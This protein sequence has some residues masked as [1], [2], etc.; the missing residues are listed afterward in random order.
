MG[1]CHF[2][3]YDDRHFGISITL[4][5]YYS[6]FGIW[7]VKCQTCKLQQC[8]WL[9]KNKCKQAAFFDQSQT[10]YYSLLSDSSV[11]TYTICLYEVQNTRIRL[12]FLIKLYKG[13]PRQLDRFFNNYQFTSV[14]NQIPY[15]L[16]YTR[17][18]VT[19]HF[20]WA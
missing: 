10:T 1:K 11:D 14:K 9:V 5:A 8:F 15:A 13:F 3:M 2:Y 20:H 16:L 7:V 17:Q 4:P 12:V 6:L 19:F 18:K